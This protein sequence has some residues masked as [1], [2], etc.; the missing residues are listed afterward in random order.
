MLAL[1]AVTPDITDAP[2]ARPLPPASRQGAELV[3]DQV[4]FRHGARAHGLT[5]ISFTVPPGRTTALVGPSG[6][7]KTSIA[8]LALRLS[9]PQAGSVRIVW[10]R[11][12]QARLGPPRS[13]NPLCAPE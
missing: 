4:T 13:A 10:V 9:D 1:M 8:R 3:F 2:N 6:A 7:G 11:L 12:C 5:D